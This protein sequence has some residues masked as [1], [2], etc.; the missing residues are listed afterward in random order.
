MEADIVR[1]RTDGA[2][3]RVETLE[4]ENIRLRRLLSQATAQADWERQRS[5]RLGRIIEAASRVEAGRMAAER[6]EAPRGPPP[7]EGAGLAPEARP[8]RERKDESIEVK[9]KLKRK[10]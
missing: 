10:D 6:A 3:R 2:E 4:A 1:P 5:R 8:R 7:R 9:K